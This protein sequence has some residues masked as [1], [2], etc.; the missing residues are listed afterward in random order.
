[1]KIFYHCKPVRLKEL[2]MSNSYTVGRRPGLIVGYDASKPQIG[3][4]MTKNWIGQNV[5]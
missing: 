4:Y 3:K 2:F 1:M 5:G